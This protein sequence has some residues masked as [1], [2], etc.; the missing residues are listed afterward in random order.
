MAKTVLFDHGFFVKEETIMYEKRS[1]TVKDL[2]RIL[3][4]S[5]PTVYKLLST[6]VF[7]WVQLKN[8]VYRIS[9]RSFDEWFDSGTDITI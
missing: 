9:K 3:N 4:V 5:K 8:G 1:Y 7:R 2:Q 6:N